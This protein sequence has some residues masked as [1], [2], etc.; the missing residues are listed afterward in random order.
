MM[1]FKSFCKVVAAC[2]VLAIAMN[3]LTLV[4][5]S[6]LVATLRA[7]V[8]SVLPIALLVSGVLIWMAAHYAYCL[9]LHSVL[10]FDQMTLEAIRTSLFLPLPTFNSTSAQRCR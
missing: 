1:N 8:D 10:G 2:Y 7:T 6:Q 3:T 9:F 5:T 4:E